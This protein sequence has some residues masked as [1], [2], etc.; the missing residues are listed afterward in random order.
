MAFRLALS[1]LQGQQQTMVF[2]LIWMNPK[3]PDE[4]SLQD[5]LVS[6]LEE[7]TLETGRQVI[8][9][10]HDPQ[11]TEIAKTRKMKVYDIG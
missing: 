1:S 3:I 11:L 5:E 4:Y 7:W 9:F 8:Y 6:T 10:T 2:P